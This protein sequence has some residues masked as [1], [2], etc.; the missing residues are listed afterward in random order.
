MILYGKDEYIAQWTL[1]FIPHVRSFGE[2]A[3]LGVLA[4]DGRLIAGCVYN[5]Y[6]PRD[7]T[8]AVSI[9]AISPMWARKE[10][11]KEL[12]RHPF[13][14]LHCYRVWSAMLA[15][16][17]PALKVNAHIGFKKEAVLAHHFGKKRHAVISRLLRPDYD[18]L[19]GAHADEQRQ[20]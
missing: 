5:E 19:Y 12:L 6:R 13:E 9:A 10:N 7:G 18:R 1:Q 8:I 20:A 11:I 15:S 3:A 16:N 17:E 2:C 4:R 14:Y